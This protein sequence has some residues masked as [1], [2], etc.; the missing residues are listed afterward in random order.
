M[1]RFICICLSLLFLSAAAKSEP[2]VTSSAGFPSGTEEKLVAF[3]N[4]SREAATPATGIPMPFRLAVLAADILATC[5]IARLVVRRR[6]SRTKDSAEVPEWLVWLCLV[7]GLLA[8][9]PPLI[10]REKS[11]WPASVGFE[12]FSLIG[13]ALAAFAALERLSWD[14]SGFAYTSIIGKT[15][16]YGLE[17]IR[18]IETTHPYGRRYEPLAYKIHLTGRSIRF[19]DLNGKLK[20]FLQTYSAWLRKRSLEPWQKTAKGNGWPCTARTDLSVKSWTALSVP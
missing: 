4:S 16:R 2:A 10:I 20:G 8:S 15:A 7:F 9:I 19:E 17:E 18:W 1:K 3:T 12:V 6:L 11:E 14:E 5:L 13:F